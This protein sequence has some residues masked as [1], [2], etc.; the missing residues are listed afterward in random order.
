MKNEK[1]YNQIFERIL[2]LRKNLKN[3]DYEY[4]L[5]EKLGLRMVGNLLYLDIPFEKVLECK[6][7]FSGHMLIIKKPK[8]TKNI[9]LDGIIYAGLN[10]INLNNCDASIFVE[11]VD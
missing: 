3:I 11:F 4:V 8:N 7:W 2:A 9:K 10:C 1:L 5:G 6:I